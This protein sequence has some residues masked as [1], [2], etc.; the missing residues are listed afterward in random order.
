[1]NRASFRRSIFPVTQE[2]LMSITS[3]FKARQGELFSPPEQLPQV[4]PEAHQRMVLLL[5]R[6]IRE[7]L[8]KGS[9]ANAEA[10]VGDE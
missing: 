7:H 8:Q 9:R 10:E 6:M 1:L 4:S 3:R 2:V 5:A